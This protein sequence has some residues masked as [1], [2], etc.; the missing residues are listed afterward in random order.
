MM[1]STLE[2]RGCPVIAVVMRPALTV[3]PIASFIAFTACGPARVGAPIPRP[4]PAPTGAVSGADAAARPGSPAAGSGTDFRRYLDMVEKVET[5]GD[6]FARPARGSAIGCYQMTDAALMDAGLKDTRGRWLRN[7]WGIDSDHEF[8]TNRRAQD[9]AMLR[10]TT[11]NWLTLEPCVRDLV[12][13]RVRGVVLDQAALLAG[14]HLLGASGLVRFVRCGLHAR[15]V[16]PQAAA[17][18][19]GRR[20][21]REVAIRRMTAARGLRIL[22]APKLGSGTEATH[23]GIRPVVLGGRHRR[24]HG[25]TVFRTQSVRGLL[26]TTAD[27]PCWHR[28]GTVCGPAQ[29]SDA[30]GSGRVG[31]PCRPVVQRSDST[32]ALCIDAIVRLCGVAA[33]SRHRSGNDVQPLPGVPSVFR[34]GTSLPS[35]SRRARRRM[36]L[37]LAG[38]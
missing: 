17:A 36:S 15:C 1:F 28:R 27:D 35:S 13:A 5:G 16:S 2:S 3:I 23:G 4:F 12:G 24:G 33:R 19:G 21:L 11:N 20:H 29:D 9:A 6:C 26:R 34:P 10:Y 7:A 32:V 25:R 22:A 18:N 37:S 14:A 30:C 31:A 8:Q 38:R